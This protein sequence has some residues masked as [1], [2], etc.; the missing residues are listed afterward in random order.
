MENANGNARGGPDSLDQELAAQLGT[1]FSSL[2]RHTGH[3]FSRYK[4]G[5]LLRRI[6]RRFQT[7][8]A[9]SGADYL[10]KPA[11]M[12][13]IEQVLANPPR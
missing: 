2:H 6:R 11:S 7:L 3:D 5:T 10:A 8:R 1:I 9:A 13:R 12:E 4:R